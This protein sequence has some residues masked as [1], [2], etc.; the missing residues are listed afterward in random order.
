MILSRYITFYRFVDLL[1]NGLYIPTALR[2]ND[3]WEGLPLLVWNSIADKKE[4]S[5]WNENVRQQIALGNSIY[6]EDEIEVTPEILNLENVQKAKTWIY[7]SCWH[8]FEDESMAMWKIYAGDRSG[9]CI[10]IDKDRLKDVFDSFYKESGKAVVLGSK[11]IY[12]SPGEKIEKANPVDFHFLPKNGEYKLNPSHYWTMEGLLIKHKAFNFENEFR[13]ICDTFFL[14]EE[15]KLKD[16]EINEICVKFPK[17]AIREVILSPGSSDKTK[18][19]VEDLLK[20]Y[21]YKCEVRK[22][23]VDMDSI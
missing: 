6:G 15:G 20:K 2:F 3:K 4:T 5:R 22:S 7:V 17:D 13:V 10:L 19:M 18:H 12:K 16:N 8:M 11:V 1:K 9:V 23:I 14:S 21:D